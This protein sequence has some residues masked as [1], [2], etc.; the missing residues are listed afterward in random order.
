MNK[1]MIFYELFVNMNYIEEIKKESI[2][3]DS[4]CLDYNLIIVVFPSFLSTLPYPAK[5]SPQISY[6]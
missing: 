2:F 4:F 5:F 3:Q 1:S 6:P